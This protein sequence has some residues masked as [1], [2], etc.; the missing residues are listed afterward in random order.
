ME[1]HDSLDYRDPL[2]MLRRFIPTPHRANYRMGAVQVAVE[3]NDFT[4]LP[5]LP[6]AEEPGESVEHLFEWKLVR[7]RDV[8]GLLEEP[9][10]LT[11]GTLTVVRMGAAC[12]LG[13]DHQR[14]ELLGFVG[15]GVDAP[16]FQEFLVPF[17]CRMSNEVI[18]G[19]MA[20]CFPGNG[21]QPAD[22]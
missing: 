3:T 14:H 5:F 10:F 8:A 20:S 1:P 12:L 9:V 11:S 19:E 13:L 15:S 16:T 18:S 22:A 21:G 2:D 4:L 7:D 6:S 17:L